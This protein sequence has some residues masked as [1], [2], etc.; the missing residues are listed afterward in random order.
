M[1]FS[2][3]WKIK[4]SLIAVSEINSPLKSREITNKTPAIIAV[5][6]TVL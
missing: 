4:V 5:K 2:I 6:I 1:V 3:N